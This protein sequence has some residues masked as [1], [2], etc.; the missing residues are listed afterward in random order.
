MHST[1]KIVVLGVAALGVAGCGSSDN[2]QGVTTILPTTTPAAGGSTAPSKLT[3]R[4]SEFRFTPKNVTAMAGVVTINAPNAGKAPHELVLL[5]TNADPANLPQKGGEVD[6]SPSVGE[7]ADV[8]P[9]TT[10][11]HH[12]KLKPGRYAMVCNLPGHYKAG[13]YGSLTVK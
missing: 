10:K 13:M 11:S 1:G 3:I 2:R 6:E 5:K 12:F 7:I 9:G 4:M 8:K